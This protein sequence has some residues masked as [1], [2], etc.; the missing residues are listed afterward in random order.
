VRHVEKKSKRN[1]LV[2]IDLTLQ[3]FEV[4]TQFRGDLVADVAVFSRA[5]LRMRSSSAGAPGFKVTGATGALRK[6]LSKTTALVLPGR[7]FAVVNWY[8]TPRGRRGRCEGRVP[9]RALVQETCRRWCR[10]RS[11]GW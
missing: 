2:G 7:E 10:R 11:R 3:A 8:R 9:R 5:L 6:M 4:G 1:N